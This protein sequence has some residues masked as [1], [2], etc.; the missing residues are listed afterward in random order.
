MA[1]PDPQHVLSLAAEMVSAREHLA[2]LQAQWDSLFTISSPEVKRAGK[3]PTDAEA[4]TT[5]IVEF[6]DAEPQ[7]HYSV[8]DLVNHFGVEKVQME[9]ALNRLYATKK[10]ARHSRG[11]YESTKREEGSQ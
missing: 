3:R 1:S 4:L 11:Q 7:Y 10:I 6:L 8:S 9:R 2:S 5:R